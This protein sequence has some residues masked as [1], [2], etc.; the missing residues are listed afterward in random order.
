MMVGL[1]EAF[2][3]D[4]NARNSQEN[5]SESGLD[6]NVF[7]INRSSTV[8]VDGDVHIRAPMVNH[9]AFLRPSFGQ[10]VDYNDLKVALSGGTGI[11]DLLMENSRN[12]EVLILNIMDRVKER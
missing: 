5:L 10:V 11:T 3:E 2:K 6:Y 4:T 8:F 9:G 7:E 1:R 12:A